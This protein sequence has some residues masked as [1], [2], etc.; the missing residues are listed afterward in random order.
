[1]NYQR[2]LKKLWQETE[3]SFQKK[4]QEKFDLQYLTFERK[5]EFLSN[6]VDKIKN[7]DTSGTIVEESML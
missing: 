2:E 3:F 7:L 1:M 6:L 5:E 4:Y